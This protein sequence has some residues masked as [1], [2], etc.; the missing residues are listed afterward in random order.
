MSSLVWLKKVML[1]FA[2]Y[3]C[4]NGTAYLQG[5]DLP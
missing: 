1:V 4:M 5:A 3:M 2:V